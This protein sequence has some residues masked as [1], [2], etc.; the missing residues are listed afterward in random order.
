MMK[1]LAKKGGG[2]QINF[3]CGFLSQANADATEKI[4]PKIMAAYKDKNEPLMDE[5]RK[6]KSLPPATLAD[7]VAHID[8]VVKLAG[9]DYAGIGSDYD[10][11]ICTP[12]GL[13]DVSK[14]PNLTRAL[15]EKGYSAE[16]MRKIYGGNLLRVMRAKRRANG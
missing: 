15:L 9:A 10:G 3:S 7:G 8:H 1:A 16:D 5:Y 2:V 12:S 11:V 6:I 13:E 4:M 14:F